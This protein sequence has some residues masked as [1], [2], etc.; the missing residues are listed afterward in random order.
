MA[1]VYGDPTFLDPIRVL[2]VGSHPVQ[3]LLIRSWLSQSGQ[4]R[5]K[6]ASHAH[7]LLARHAIF[8]PQRT[9]IEK[10]LCDDPKERLHRRLVLRFYFHVLGEC[11]GRTIRKLIG[12]GGGGGGGFL[13]CKNFFSFRLQ[14]YARIFFLNEICFMHNLLLNLLKTV[15]PV[16]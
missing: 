2:S 15:L 8:P 9:F 3:V 13:A 12:G 10:G 11:K 1:V 16:L 7:R 4:A 14:P 6:V 5:F